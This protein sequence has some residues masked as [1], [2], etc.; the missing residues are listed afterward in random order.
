VVPAA[1][2]LGYQ[3]LAVGRNGAES[4]LANAMSSAAQFGLRA[5]AAR[6]VVREVCAA[7][8]GWKR[9][10]SDAGVKDDDIDYLARFIDRD[11]LRLQR[12]ECNRGG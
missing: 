12:A 10:F 7:V 4:T 6:T 11:A 3:Q 2:G 9:A 1:Q 8:E 5:A